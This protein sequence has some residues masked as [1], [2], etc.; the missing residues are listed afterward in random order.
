M[1][2]GGVFT[3]D[4]DELSASGGIYALVAKRH[5]S[6]KVAMDVQQDNTTRHPLSVLR[7]TPYQP[8]SPHHFG[9][10]R[11]IKL[12]SFFF[13]W[14]NKSINQFSSSFYKH[15]CTSTWNVP[16]PDAP[17]RR[18]WQLWWMGSVDCWETYVLLVNQ[19][20]LVISLPYCLSFII[21][22]SL[23]HHK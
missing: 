3:T 8:I 10:G 14:I 20:Q 11:K 5:D 6:I 15:L 7:Q 4:G 13:E 9:M 19:Y 23:V 18:R 21:K 1:A 16:I 22:S 2:P 17:C 12:F